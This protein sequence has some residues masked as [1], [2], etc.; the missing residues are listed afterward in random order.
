MTSRGIV[1]TVAALANAV[2]Q[3]G[4]TVALG[5]VGAAIDR[6][7]QPWNLP[8]DRAVRK[9]KQGEMVELWLRDR[10]TVAGRYRGLRWFSAEAYRPR[11]EAA[12]AALR[13]DTVLPALGPG[14]RLVHSSGRV[15]TGELVGFG[16][17][18]VNM[19]ADGSG[20]PRLV[21][22]DDLLSVE[23]RENR[24]VSRQRLRELMAAGHLPSLAGLAI[25][26][27]TGTDNVE[28]EKVV[29]IRQ[30]KEPSRPANML[31]GAAIGLVIDVMA[32]LALGQ[33][34]FGGELPRP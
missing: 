29:G 1:L 11:Y 32:V 19:L 28:Y 17:E 7:Q 23:D 31:F 8:A 9:V 5:G 15:S 21:P 14:A 18:C 22:L 34:S 2:V 6:S 25:E 16:P 20:T 4:C 33:E 26:R 3:S 30:L 27:E 10:Q 24:S 13:P 12:R